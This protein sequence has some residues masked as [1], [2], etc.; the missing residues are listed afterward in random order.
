M[1]Q[2]QE[3]K[4]DQKTV[5][6][7]SWLYGYEIHDVTQTLFSPNLLSEIRTK[8]NLQV[9]RQVKNGHHV[10][11]YVAVQYCSSCCVN[12]HAMAIPQGNEEELCATLLFDLKKVSTLEKYVQ[13]HNNAAQFLV[14]ASSKQ[15]KHK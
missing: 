13:S 7:L 8:T 11:Y 5:L 1:Q 12:K 4:C 3:V 6:H 10:F 9:S 14:V 15:V 2:A